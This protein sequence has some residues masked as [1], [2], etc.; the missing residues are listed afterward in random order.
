MPKNN[1]TPIKDPHAEREASNYDN[2]IPSRE[3]ILEVLREANKPLNHN[4][5][6]KKLQLADHEQVDALRKRLRA[7]ERDGQIMSDRKG[8]YGLVDKMNLVHCRVQ[9]HRD[10]YGF[11]MPVKEGD[12]IYLGSRQMHFVFDGDEV[13]VQVTGEDRRGRLEGRVVE[14]LERK[15]KTVVGRYQEESEEEEE[16]D[17]EKTMK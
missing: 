1:N 8:A 2:P 13:L 17:K 12:D 5:L 6:C 3:V 15:H 11:A 16:H 9:G 7:M 4:K 14:V 10:G